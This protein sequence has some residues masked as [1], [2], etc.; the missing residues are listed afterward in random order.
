MGK[1]SFRS[2]KLLF[3]YWPDHFHFLCDSPNEDADDVELYFGKGLVSRKLHNSI[4]SKCKFDSGRKGVECEALL[5]KMDKEVG[6]HNVYNVY[7]NC[8]GYGPH[9]DEEDSA[10][11]TTHSLKRWMEHSGKSMRWLR[12]FLQKPENMANPGVAHAQLKAMGGGYDWTC[13]QVR[14]CC[15]V[16]SVCYVQ[17]AVL[18]VERCAEL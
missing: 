12:R 17:C 13:G 2:L 16:C 10:E 9:G 5:E 15:A 11:G 6:P 18:R 1:L 3:R 7:D 8:P 4:M 14:T